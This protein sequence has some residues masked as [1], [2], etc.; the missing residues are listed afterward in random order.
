MNLVE[1][2]EMEL[3]RQVVAEVRKTPYRNTQGSAS[4]PRKRTCGLSLEMTERKLCYCQ[5]QRRVPVPTTVSVRY[6]W[7]AK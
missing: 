2:S 1:R 4:L 3:S 5:K 6:A 7:V